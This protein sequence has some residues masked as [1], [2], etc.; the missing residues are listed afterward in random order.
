MSLSPLALFAIDRYNN[1]HPS[2]AV[3]FITHI[4]SVTKRRKTIT[5]KIENFPRQRLD[6][7]I[8]NVPNDALGAPKA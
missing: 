6:I 1:R 4:T 2:L 7:P 3:F 8:V 5:A